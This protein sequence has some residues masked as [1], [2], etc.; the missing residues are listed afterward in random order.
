[1]D[2]M[3]IGICLI[4]ILL[5]LVLMIVKIEQYMESVDK[6]L[7]ALSEHLLRKDDQNAHIRTHNFSLCVCNRCENAVR[8]RPCGIFYQK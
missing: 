8:I 5:I 3:V 4:V 1:M 6:Q 7:K 2:G